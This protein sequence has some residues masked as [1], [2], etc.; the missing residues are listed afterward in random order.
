M[1]FSRKLLF[2]LL[3]LTITMNGVTA[4]AAA[5]SV[6]SQKEPLRV[7]YTNWWGDYTLLV[8]DE[9]GMFEKYGVNVEPVFY[10]TYSDSYSD[11]AAGLLDGGLFVL[12]DAININDKSPLKVIAVYDDG[13]MD[14]LIGDTNI[15]SIADLKGK[16]I[17]VNI[18]SAG[19]LV[20]LQALKQAGLKV[21]D[22]TLVDMSVEELPENLGSTVDAGYSWDPY[23]SEALKNGANILYQSGGTNTIGPD[24][25]VFNANTL[26]KRSEEIRSFL[27]AWFEA[28]DFR[29]SN[30]E[31]AN[32]I[33]SARTGLSID[34][35]S[36]DA[37]LYTLQQNIVLLS[38]QTPQ[39]NMINL[40]SAFN[41]NAEF[42]LDLGVLSNQPDKN[43]FIDSSFLFQ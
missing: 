8:A 29:N 13:G 25:I 27:K 34:Q 14:Y 2:H 36:V 4:C 10:E 1:N 17:G 12:G 6:D 7:E 22:V 39:D 28:V 30:P 31:S 19:E 24:V 33:I 5:Q 9:M 42:L 11:L 41:A 35:L 26:E 23:A 20:V 43:Q 15:K 38:D 40:T 18:S 32:Q 3:V 21:E 37:E 16:K